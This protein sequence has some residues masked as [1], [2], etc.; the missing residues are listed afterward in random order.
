MNLETDRPRGEQ[1]RRRA[2][3]GPLHLAVG[4]SSAGSI[5]WAVWVHGVPGAVLGVTDDLGHGPLA[6]GPSR[7]RYLRVCARG[8]EEPPPEMTDAFAS[9]EFMDDLLDPVG[10]REVVI[11]GGDNVAETTFL[12]LACWSLSDRRV[13]VHR[14]S[15]P[16]GDPRRYVAEFL[17]A[18]LAGLYAARREVGV[19]E[20]RF[21][22]S[23]FVRIR[24]TTGFLRRWEDGRIIG[25][26][27]DH[28]D[29]LLLRVCGRDWIPAPRVVGAAMGRC[30]RANLL[31]DLFFS[32]RLQVLIDGGRIEADGPRRSL[33]DYAVRRAGA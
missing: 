10:T 2:S 11:W 28:Y 1:D 16:D 27:V 22:A 29:A 19:E 5:R 31:N 25:V 18:E 20:R 15:T 12:A 8:Y 4:D 6:D 32:S 26:A 3:D 14:V 13:T 24:E 9:L 17:P 23:E 33:R 7:T 30:D 21:L